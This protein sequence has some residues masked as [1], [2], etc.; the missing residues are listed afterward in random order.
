MIW[1]L[2]IGLSHSVYVGQEF[3]KSILKKWVVER[4]NINGAKKYNIIE[5]FEFGTYIDDYF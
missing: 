4:L 5:D 2:P 3:H 1:T